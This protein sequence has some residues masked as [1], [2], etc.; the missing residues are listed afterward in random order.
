M[1]FDEA[2]GPRGIEEHL[3]SPQGTEEGEGR[4][5]SISRTRKRFHT[6]YYLMHLHNTRR[7]ASRWVVSC[8]C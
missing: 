8:C 5:D 1:V 3:Y 7:A 2:C 6:G 4:N